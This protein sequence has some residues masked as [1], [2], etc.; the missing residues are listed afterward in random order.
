MKYIHTAKA[1]EAV[2]HYSQAVLEGNLVFCSGQIAIDPATSQI[3]GGSAAQQTERILLNIQAIL[4]EA[5]VDFRHVIKTTIFLK[6]MADVVAVNEVYARHLGD[7]KP[8]RST[9]EVARLPKGV[10]V[11]IECIATTSG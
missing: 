9:V 5:G 3:A 4:A 2:G 10:A 1:P 8:A 6:N 7:H 11:E